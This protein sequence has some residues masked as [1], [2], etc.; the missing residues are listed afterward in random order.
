MVRKRG[1]SRDQSTDYDRKSGKLS[2]H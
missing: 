2:L 1:N